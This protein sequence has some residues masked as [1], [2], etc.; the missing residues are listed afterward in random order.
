[1]TQQP[2]CGPELVAKAILCHALQ[3]AGKS[4]THGISRED[5]QQQMAPWGA[6]AA[7]RVLQ[8]SAA[9]FCASADSVKLTATGASE[10]P[11]LSG[12]GEVLAVMA[13]IIGVSGRH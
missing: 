1:M 2:L 6:D 5:F 11:K 7:E 3:L 8:G 12:S 10:L 4:A 9:L 13:D